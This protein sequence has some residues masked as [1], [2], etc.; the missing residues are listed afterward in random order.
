MSIEERDEIKVVK[1]LDGSNV[2]SAAVLKQ[3]AVLYAGE[4]FACLRFDS[5]RNKNGIV[6]RKSTTSQKTFYYIGG[7]FEMPNN[8]YHMCYNKAFE[9]EQQAIWLHCAYPAKIIA[10]PDFSPT[11]DDI[12]IISTSLHDS[13]I[14]TEMEKKKRHLAK[15][16]MKRA[17]LGN[18]PHV[19]LKKK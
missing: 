15:P 9:L 2:Y 1:V 16:L 5:D 6:Y 13:I 4:K 12:P 10:S 3:P 19:N 18:N 8:E 14:S 11:L 17:K 7:I